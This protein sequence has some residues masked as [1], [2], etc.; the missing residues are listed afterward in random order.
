M[1]RLL[2]VRLTVVAA[3]FISFGMSATKAI[4]QT[5]F[6]F[7]T[8]YN[9]ISVFEEVRPGISQITV[10]GKSETAPYG[11]TNLSSLSYGQ[12]NLDTSELITT[13]DPA[14]FGNSDLPFGENR[15]F[16]SDTD[17]SIFVRESVTRPFPID[18]EN[19]TASIFSTLNITGGSGRFSG[20]TGT[21]NVSV[22]DILAS[23]ST[24]FSRGRVKY[25]GSFQTPQAI[26][27]PRNVTMLVGMGAIGV[28]CLVRRRKLGVVS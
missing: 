13:Q 23:D 26:P 1:L 20:A 15:I 28:G 5:I 16:N 25:S 24:A 2:A 3:T 21:L 8:I 12:L 27:E 17:D 10:T 9:T 11:L 22:E 18:F 19:Q 7:E 6:P 4:A 14:R